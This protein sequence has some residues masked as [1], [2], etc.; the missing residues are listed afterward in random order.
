MSDIA[1]EAMLMSQ[2]GNEKEINE[3]KKQSKSKA[4]K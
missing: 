3:Q 4:T 2:S 1:K